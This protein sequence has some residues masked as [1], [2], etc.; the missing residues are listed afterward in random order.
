M[1]KKTTANIL[2]QQPQRQ[3]LDGRWD[4][5]YLVQYYRRPRR[6][7]DVIHAVRNSHAQLQNADQSD[8]LQV[9][10]LVLLKR[11]IDIL[12]TVDHPTLIRLEDVYE[13]EANLHLVRRA[14]S[15]NVLQ[16]KTVP[17]GDSICSC[18]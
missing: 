11:E 15:P 12:R 3:H 10:R 14:T 16:R 1:K 6:A 7:V 13:D 17:F 4:R 18:D 5:A 9:P 2:Q 8:R